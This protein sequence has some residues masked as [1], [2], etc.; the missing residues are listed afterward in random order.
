MQIYLIII[1]FNLFR[2]ILSFGFSVILTLN[3]IILDG[4]TAASDD[5]TF[6]PTTLLL[7]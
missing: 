4:C 2:L 6:H 5:V 7:Q 3:L 1:K